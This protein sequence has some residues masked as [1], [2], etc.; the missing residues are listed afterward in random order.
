M[1]VHPFTKPTLNFHNANNVQYVEYNVIAQ[2]NGE[3][4]TYFIIHTYC[5]MYNLTFYVYTLC[6]REFQKIFF[7]SLYAMPVTHY[8]HRGR[9]IRFSKG[10][11]EATY[12]LEKKSLYNSSHSDSKLSSDIVFHLVPTQASSFLTPTCSSDDGDSVCHSSCF[13]VS[14][15]WWLQKYNWSTVVNKPPIC[16]YS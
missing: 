6:Y 13:F 16:S 8:K 5:I 15:D 12:R 10:A 11:Y 1:S 4:V 9:N 2:L 3:D 7:L 14:S